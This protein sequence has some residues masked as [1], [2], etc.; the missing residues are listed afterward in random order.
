MLWCHLIYCC[1]PKVLSTPLTTSKPIFISQ[2]HRGWNSHLI[3]LCFQILQA[4]KSGH[5]ASKNTHT[6]SGASR[7]ASTFQQSPFCPSVSKCFPSSHLVGRSSS[8]GL[9]W[10]APCADSVSAHKTGWWLQD[11]QSLYEG[12]H[13]AVT[14]AKHG[15]RSQEHQHRDRDGQLSPLFTKQPPRG[16]REACWCLHSIQRCLEPKIF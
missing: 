12:R 8:S 13:R 15:S 4:V 5:S 6:G 11:K 2:S 3:V 10:W 9:H 16:T 14:R 7:W 1:F